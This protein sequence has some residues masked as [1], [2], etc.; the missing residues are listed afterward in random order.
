MKQLYLIRHAKSS[1][2]DPYVTDFKRKLNGRGKVDASAMAA[3]LAKRKII[4]DYIVSS[5]AKRAKKTVKIFAKAVAF[6]RDDIVYDKDIY[7]SSLDGLFWVVHG[8]DDECDTAF[9]VGHNY[10]ITEFAEILTG[11]RFE[12]IPTSGVVAIDLSVSSW[13]EVQGGSGKC[14][15]FD[16]PKKYKLPVN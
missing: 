11:E 1:W 7:F 9:F 12:N 13:S 8:I 4:P 16:Y 15:F 6:D 2:S 5:P 10:A 14:V 3:R